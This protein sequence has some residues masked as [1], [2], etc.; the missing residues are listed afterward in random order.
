MRPRYEVLVEVTDNGLVGGVQ[1]ERLASQR[2][3]EVVLIDLNEP[4]H[5]V[6][7]GVSVFE[8]YEGPIGQPLSDMGTDEDADS[9][10][11]FSLHGALHG[12]TRI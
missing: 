9:L 11:E 1:H 6:A 3:I 4:P 12:I 10:L 2:R 5:L 8:N 7:P